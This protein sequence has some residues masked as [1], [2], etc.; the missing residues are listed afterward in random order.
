[1]TSLDRLRETLQP[2]RRRLIAHGVYE[3]I[4]SPEA[5]QTFVEHHIFAV[6]DFMS[7]LK[8]LQREL[9]CV[10][11]PWVPRG[12]AK[13]RRLINEIVLA[14]E[15]D[16]N[17]LGGYAS[18]FELYLN[19][20]TVL[21]ADTSR[22]EG[23]LVRLRHGESVQDA[24]A[25]SE[26]P[27]A[28]ESFVRT[29]WQIISSGSLPAIAAAFALGREEVIPDMFLKVVTRL[30]Q[31]SPDRLD[32]F[33]YYLERHIELDGGEHAH[34]ALDMLEQICDNAPER[35]RDA[36]AAAELSLEARINLWNG[37]LHSINPACPSS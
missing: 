6:W 22:I 27:R 21:G 16:D 36:T 11:I 23:F 15:S 14:E 35:W 3:S 30:R 5:L 19:A 32:G 10:E 31:Q 25:S 20:M 17:G 28:A 9:T 29:T 1:M 26:V 4:D 13:S 24:L 12:N 33:Y 7:L 34:L 2:L 8:A 18:H 37:V